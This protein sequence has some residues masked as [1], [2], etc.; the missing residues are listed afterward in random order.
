MALNLLT[1]HHE[2]CNQETMHV[3]GRKMSTHSFQ[4]PVDIYKCNNKARIAA[5][6]VLEDAFHILSNAQGRIEDR[7][8]KTLG[9]PGTQLPDLSIPKQ[10]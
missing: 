4:E 3:E 7:R 2:T 8:D 10:A 5:F 6:G 9:A 1:S